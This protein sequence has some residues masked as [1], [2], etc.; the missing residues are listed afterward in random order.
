M[1]R[2]RASRR[3]ARPA[4]LRASCRARPTSS[5]APPR[6]RRSACSAPSART[7]CAAALARRAARPPER[8]GTRMKLLVCGGAGFIGS[9]FVPPAR[10]RP[11][12]RRSSCST[13]SPT[14]AA[15]RTSQDVEHTFVH[16]AIED[17]EAV[18]EAM[19]GVD[20]VV[21]FAAETHV[22][23]SIAEPDAFVTHARA[24]HVRAARGGAPARPALRPGLDRRGLRLDRGGLVH[25]DLAA[26]PVLAVQR[27]E[28]RRRPARRGRTSTRTGSRRSSAAG[29]TTTGRTSTPRS[30]S[31]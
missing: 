27:D 19:E 31:R 26:R 14:P 20:A 10:A 3:C 9:N 22:D 1:V 4:S 18:R 11:R 23:R 7:A 16:G 5:P 12:R 13:S 17:A 25:R 21:N 8:A 24:G 15:G 28:G 30:S 2:A 6:G 29:R